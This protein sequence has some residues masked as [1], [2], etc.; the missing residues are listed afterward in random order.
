MYRPFIEEGDLV[1]DVGAHVGDRTSSFRRLGA[2]VV[3]IEP[4][5]AL[6]RALALIHGGDAMVSIERVAVGRELGRARMMINSDNP[7]VSTLSDAFAGRGR[8]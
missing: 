3:A 4:Q 8:G 2:R 1:F 5:P 7:T 6:G